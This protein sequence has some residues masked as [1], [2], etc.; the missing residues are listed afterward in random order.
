MAATILI[1]D[2]EPDIRTILSQSL[3]MEGYEVT[4]AVDGHDAIN[5][6]QANPTD[7][8]ITDMRM[9]NADGLDVLRAVKSRDPLVEVIV[10]TGYAT[11]K[12]AVSALKSEGAFHYLTKPLEDIEEFLTTVRNALERQLLRRQNQTLLDRLRDKNQ[13]LQMETAAVETS[14]K[15][16]EKALERFTSLVNAIPSGV[17]E[18]D[19]QGIIQYANAAFYTIFGLPPDALIGRPVSRLMPEEAQDGELGSFMETIVSTTPPPSPSTTTG[20]IAGGNLI[21]LQVDWNHQYGSEGDVTG[22]I[23]VMTDITAQKEASEQ[24]LDLEK[25]LSSAQ[26]K[27]AISTLAGG[28]AHRFNNALAVVVG[29][30]E[31]LELT[32]GGDESLKVYIDRIMHQTKGMAQ[33]TQKLLAYAQ[34][35]RYRAK[36]LNLGAFVRESLPIIRHGLETEREIEL[37]VAA[38]QI[39]IKVDPT[40]LELVLSALIQNAVEATEAGDS[41]WI[42]ADTL[43][44]APD[45]IEGLAPGPCAFL[46]IEDG[47][48]GMAPAVLERLFEPYFS[49]KF[50]GRGLGMAAVQGIITNHQGGIQVASKAGKGTTVSI[51]L[52]LTEVPAV[53]TPAAPP[54]E[55]LE[56]FNLLI[57]EDEPALL[58]ACEA[59]LTDLGCRVWCAPTAG[60]GIQQLEA[61]QK[62][63]DLVLM[64]LILPDM[65]AMALFKA[66]RAIKPE[67]CVVLCSGYSIDGPAQAIIDAGAISFL[68][69]P[70]STK[71]L[72][73]S[74]T[75]ATAGGD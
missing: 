61:H 50:E 19:P 29:N 46:R 73:A 51:Y 69:K 11:V 31:L 14:R 27:E 38:E 8:V 45:D 5:Q 18:F 28:I 13:A 54:L 25:R 49:T 62:E 32:T 1:V 39:D 59:M 7:L 42:M 44:A 47:G 33:Q 40:Q 72:I 9:P 71:A 30:L 24:R 63:I 36:H 21:D 68:Q 4:S 66:L 74:L 43:A 34:G 20:A 53:E 37:V 12:N 35:G 57:I 48:R 65:G 6:F 3:E 56:G 58:A 16:L 75:Q 60:S 15:D 26:K 52:P 67:L 23:A 70:Y 22:Y 41:I 55:N 2:D 64:D 17:L 10:L